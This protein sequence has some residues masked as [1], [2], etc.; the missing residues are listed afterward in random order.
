M[1]SDEMDVVVSKIRNFQRVVDELELLSRAKTMKVIILDGQFREVTKEFYGDE[2]FRSIVNEV[3]GSLVMKKVLYKA[4]LQG[5]GV[6][7]DDTKDE[8]ENRAEKRP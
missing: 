7:V 6:T 8:I 5:L 3:S 2:H 4:E 1:K